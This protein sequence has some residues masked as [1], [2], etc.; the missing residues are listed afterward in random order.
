MTAHFRGFIHVNVGMGYQHSNNYQYQQPYTRQ[1]FYWY[2]LG[3]TIC[4]ADLK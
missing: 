2:S 4:V 1:G 3:H